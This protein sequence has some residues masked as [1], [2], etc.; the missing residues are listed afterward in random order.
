MK[1]SQPMSTASKQQLSDI[2]LTVTLWPSAFLVKGLLDA[3]TTAVKIYENDPQTWS[4]V[5]RIVEKLNAAQ[6]LT[7][8]LTPS[9]VCMMSNDDRCFVCG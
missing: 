4:E 9:M 8:T 6:Q 3:H 7:A 5:I 2:P 1:L